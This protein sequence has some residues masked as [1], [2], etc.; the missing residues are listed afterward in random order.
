MKLYDW[1]VAPNPRRVRMYLAEKGIEIE[2]VEVGEPGQARLS[3]AYL[4]SNPHRIVPALELD[5]RTLIGEAPAICRYLESQYPEP[6]LLGRDP[7]E[8]A[9][10]EMWDRKCEIEGMQACAEILRNKVKAFAGRGLPGY[11]VPI[12]QI[13]ALVDRGLVRLETFYEKLDRRLGESEFVAGDVF[14]GADITGFVAVEMASRGGNGIPE[15]CPNVARWHTAI[16]ARPSAA[17]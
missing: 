2:T 1:K 4:A 3:E 10:V 17:A 6:P 11:R 8:R 13:P 16:A 7:R 9:I 14:T 5:D 12:P 15:G